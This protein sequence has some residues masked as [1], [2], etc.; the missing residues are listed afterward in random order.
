M[1]TVFFR[2]LLTTL[3]LFIPIVAMTSDA[4]KTPEV[5]L[6][7]NNN[8]TPYNKAVE[9]NICPASPQ[10]GIKNNY[11]SKSN[12]EY[13]DPLLHFFSI[14]N[15]NVENQKT[16]TSL[17]KSN[18]NIEE[19]LENNT[20]A[21]NIDSF[22]MVG[23]SPDDFKKIEVKG[24]ILYPVPPGGCKMALL[25]YRIWNYDFTNPNNSTSTPVEHETLTPT[26]LNDPSLTSEL[27]F[28]EVNLSE[29]KLAF[30]NNNPNSVLALQICGT[31]K[32]YY[33]N[34]KFVVQKIFIPSN[35][36][37]KKLFDLYIKIGG[38]SFTMIATAV[39]YPF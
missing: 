19:F 31:D 21:P 23:T 7:N 33:A 16:F 25:N 15:L 34:S 24:S 8:V 18:E 22:K 2:N 28:V 12:L 37:F 29:T 17:V 10:K 6:R 39:W 38:E 1:K 4:S 30:L 36:P 13:L 26:L 32:T 20:K 5:S 35:L 11:F 9:N 3:L 14:S 27:C